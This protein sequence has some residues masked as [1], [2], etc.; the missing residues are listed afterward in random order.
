MVTLRYQ[1]KEKD[2]FKQFGDSYIG[3]LIKLEKVNAIEDKA[4]KIVVNM[5]LFWLLM[6]LWDASF[7]SDDS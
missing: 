4:E 3:I 1:I 6:L 5:H 2:T 7:N